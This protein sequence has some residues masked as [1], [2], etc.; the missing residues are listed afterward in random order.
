MKSN[1]DIYLHVGLAKTATT[2]IQKG[3]TENDD[4]LASKGWL[5]PKSG[6]TGI[7]S[8]VQAH[9][10]L[11]FE[12]AKPS[13]FSKEAGG[14]E[15]IVE[16]IRKSDKS[17]IIISS[18]AFGFQT[19]DIIRNTHN[20]FSSLGRV[21]IIVYIRPQEE[22]LYSL[23]S[24]EVK[25]AVVQT[26]FKEWLNLRSSQYDLFIAINRWAAIFGQ[27]NIKVKILE[28]R[29]DQEHIFIDFLRS[30]GVKEFED[31]VLP[32]SMNVSPSAKTLEVIRQYT[33][34]LGV[35]PHTPDPGITF[36]PGDVARWI[37]KYAATNGWNET[38]DT[39]ISPETR[40]LIMKRHEE[41]NRKLAEKFF[42]R[43]EL[44]LNRPDEKPCT[45]FS[46]DDLQREE[47]IDLSAFILRKI[48]T[49]YS[50]QT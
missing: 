7:A 14:F 26:T 2:T 41:S 19:E 33:L 20:I 34:R 6:R 11:V 29:P 17:N 1:N 18:E 23:W 3:L 9:H 37:G 21:T 13:R 27:E 28:S 15:S 5:Y 39:F 30:C 10:N 43:D 50:R 35:A 47:M 25:H 31:I 46:I 12:M 44:F 48:Y 49:R 8:I 36:F 22:W 45:T 16:E 42:G 4:F 40:I 24:E 38:K 32:T